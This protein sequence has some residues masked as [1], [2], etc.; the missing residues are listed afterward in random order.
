MDCPQVEEASL[1]Q[2]PATTELTKRQILLSLAEAQGLGFLC[3]L[4]LTERKSSEE[5]LQA[6]LEVCILRADSS[7]L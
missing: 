5:R 2:E 4:A 7:D 6:R 3:A 1:A